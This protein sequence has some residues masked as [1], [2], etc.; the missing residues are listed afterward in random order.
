MLGVG[1]TEIVQV[2]CVIVLECKS[3]FHVLHVRYVLVSK[4]SQ[5]VPIC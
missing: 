3:I 4:L 5:V 2:L 1:V